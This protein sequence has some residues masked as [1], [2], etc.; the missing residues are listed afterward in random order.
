MKK[1][2]SKPKKKPLKKPI[3]QKPS[4]GL[5]AQPKANAAS[6]REESHLKRW[7]REHRITEVEC[8]VPDITGNARGKIIPATKFSTITA[9]ACRRAFSPPRSPANT[10][11]STTKS[12]AP[13]IPT[14][15]CAPIRTPCAWCLGP[16]IRPCRSSTTASPAKAN[17]TNWRRAMCCAACSSATKRWV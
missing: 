9:R 5:V 17:R 10:S 2:V 3:G 8:L 15:T 4:H 11:T 6:E 7:L 12:S 16:A 1:T 14:C 13:P